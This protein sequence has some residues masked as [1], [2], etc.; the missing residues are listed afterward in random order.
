MNCRIILAALAAAISFP[1]FSADPP[2]ETILVKRGGITVTAGDIY[3]YLDKLPEE[4]RIYNRG[5]VERITNAASTIYLFRVLASQARAQ[6]MDKEPDYAA[7][8]KIMEET[9]LAQM[10]LAR[11]E[12]SIVVPDYHDVAKEMYKANPDRYKV[13]ATMRL[14]QIIVGN[15]GRTDE[16][17]R[18][19]AEEARARILAGTP[20]D[21]ALVRE[22][23]T[24]PRARFNDGLLEGPYN[25]VA[26]EIQAVARTIALNTLSDPIKTS[27]GYAIIRV[28]ERVAPSV[29]PFK[30]VEDQLVASEE[31]KFKRTAMDEKL[32]TITNSKDI[33][34][35]TN[36]IASLVIETDRAKLQQ[37]HEDK[38]RDMAE[39]KKELLEPAAKPVGK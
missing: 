38:A 24:D 33:V 30:D 35:D 27:S 23:S 15:Q 7:R 4:Q 12:K 32:G 19:R 3:A 37:M 10:Y 22:Y 20:F 8:L 5:D 36:A 17:T 1:A 14:R 21:G 28:E 26:P 31:K 6:G 9:M 34:I 18:K 11:Y 39:R 13:P 16:E 29:T 25:L 2:P